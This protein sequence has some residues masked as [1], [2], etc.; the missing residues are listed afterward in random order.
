MLSH[1][2]A[3][4]ETPYWLLPHRAVSPR[5]EEAAEVAIPKMTLTLAGVLSV[6]SGGGDHAALPSQPE[7]PSCRQDGRRGHV[8]AISSARH[9]AV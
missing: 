5:A 7:P 9:L 8:C 4:E 2:S 6:A 1:S 3:P